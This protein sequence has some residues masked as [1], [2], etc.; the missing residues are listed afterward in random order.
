MV[1]KVTFVSFARIRLL[2]L[3]FEKINKIPGVF[4]TVYFMIMVLRSPHHIVYNNRKQ[5]VS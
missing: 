4:A 2:S 5:Q 3:I 1:L